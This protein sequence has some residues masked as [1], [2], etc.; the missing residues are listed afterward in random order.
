MLYPPPNNMKG[1]LFWTIQSFVNDLGQQSGAS[2][3]GQPILWRN[4][5]TQFR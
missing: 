5:L 3:Y 1:A 2:I 4:E